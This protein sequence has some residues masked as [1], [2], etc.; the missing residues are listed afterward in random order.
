MIVA[1][2]NVRLA[3]GGA[4]SIALDIHRRRILSNLNSVY[5]YGYGKN[6]K[7]S[8]SHYK[9]HNVQKITNQL[10]AASN[11]L[12]YPYFNHDLLGNPLTNK[13]FHE[14]VED[15]KNIL[16]MH[17]LHSHFINS[18]NF[19]HYIVKN[20]NK[21]VWT[22]HDHWA[23]TGRCAFTDLC[24]RW[25]NDCFK[26]ETLNNYPRVKLDRASNL[27]REKRTVIN[28]F[29]DNGGILVSPSK[30]LAEMVNQVYGNGSCKIIN[31]GIDID[32]EEVISSVFSKLY[33]NETTKKLKVAV[34]AHD[35]KYQGKT[36]SKFI[37]KVAEKLSGNIEI[38]IIGKNSPFEGGQ[39][40]NHGFI[41]EKGI[42][43]KKLSEM[44]AL[45]FTSTV[46]NYP[47]ILCEALSLGVPVIA[48]KSLAAEEIL[49]AVGAKCFDEEEILD[50]LS[51]G[52][53]AL[54]S[55]FSVKSRTE[56]SELSRSLFSGFNML[57]QYKKIYD[58][59]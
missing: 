8:E 35:L 58:T 25:R 40:I 51:M 36:N 1:Q 50:L 11:L 55:V 33:E 53:Q 4:A 26:C 5:F 43:I 6:G 24:E 56:L 34:V 48:T 17:V 21:A 3:E 10:V 54:Y 20:K 13:A 38:H 18:H 32:T 9:Y 14:F 28:A 31:N 41:S 23:I 16:H 49:R 44:D 27:I 52:R 22:L 37:E 29:I 46:D 15:K 39:Y 45:L 47:V 30:H 19:L 12:L 57:N 59:L 2:F 7:V 42:L